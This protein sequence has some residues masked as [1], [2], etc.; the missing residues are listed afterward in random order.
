MSHIDVVSGSLCVLRP[1][2]CGIRG[3]NS[4]GA[5]GTVG[6]SGREIE[7]KGDYC[8]TIGVSWSR[9]GASGRVKSARAGMG[10]GVLQTTA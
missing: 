2:V 3:A 4:R 9:G 8:I 5:R 10:S 6:A 7:Y 1:R